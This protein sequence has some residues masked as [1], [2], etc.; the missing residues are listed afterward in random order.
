M[1]DAPP[2]DFTN[3]RLVKKFP[4]EELKR[5]Y[6]S[7]VFLGEPG[8]VVCRELIDALWALR[9]AVFEWDNTSEPTERIDRLLVMLR[10]ARGE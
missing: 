3:A 2:I 8:D 5:M 9:R 4:D 10:I 6:A 7:A 1:A